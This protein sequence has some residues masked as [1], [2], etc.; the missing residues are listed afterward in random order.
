LGENACRDKRASLFCKSIICTNEKS[1]MTQAPECQQHA[2]IF[3]IS[4]RLTFTATGNFKLSGANVK[5]FI[6]VIDEWA[7]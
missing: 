7:K 3:K 5:K 4:D 2:V 1:F 6:F